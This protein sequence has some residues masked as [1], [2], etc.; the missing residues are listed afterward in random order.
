MV[1]VARQQ[2][3]ARDTTI[4]KTGLDPAKGTRKE[5]SGVRKPRRKE[6]QPTKPAEGSKALPK[7]T[8]TRQVL[9][10]GGTYRLRGK[11]TTIQ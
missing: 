1:T 8:Q 10:I 2:T 5:S 3:V 6:T 9:S 7:P 4:A 11:A